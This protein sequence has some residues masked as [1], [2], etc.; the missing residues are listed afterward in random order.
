MPWQPQH[1]WVH[2][3]PNSVGNTDCSV[4]YN[5]PKGTKHCITLKL[6]PKSCVFFLPQQENCLNADV[7]EQIYKRNPILR[8]T[9]HPLHSPLLPLPYGDINL[10]CK[11]SNNRNTF[12]YERLNQRME[13]LSLQWSN[14]RQNTCYNTNRQVSLCS[15]ENSSL[16]SIEPWA[17]GVP[18]RALQKGKLL[19][20]SATQLRRLSLKSLA[21]K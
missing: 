11:S 10:N 6:D 4:F 17:C 19:L 8:Y 15:F 1:P 12:P 14:G 20:L 3:A 7:V 13:F 2:L 18:A 9:H 5:Q 16:P 21:L